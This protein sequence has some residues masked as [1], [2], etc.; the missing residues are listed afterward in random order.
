MEK[1]IVVTAVIPAQNGCNLHC[2]GC[3]ISQRGEAGTNVL[4]SEDY[5]RFTEDTLA[6][7]EVSSFSLQ[8]FEP[9]LPDAWPLAK[10]LLRI[11][12]MATTPDGVGKRVLCVT[13]G[14]YLDRHAE[15][16]VHIT[17]SLSVSVDSHDSAIHDLSRGVVGAWQDTIRGI[18]A[19]RALFGEEVETF[20]EYLGVVSI[21]YPGKVNRLLGMPE[22]LASLGVKRWTVSPLISIAKDGFHGNSQLIR[23]NILELADKAN[24]YGVEV[25]LGDDL[26]Q[27]ESVEDLYKVLSVAAVAGDHV[28]VRLSPDASLSVGKEILGNSADSQKWDRVESP[29][30]FLKRT[31]AKKY[32]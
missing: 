10:E 18:R 29:V 19:V 17:D 20:Q 25:F 14:V 32:S 6:M 9:L 30:Q 4:T 8:G 2:A 5:L 3:I 31:V 21:L 26:R 16:L 1:R 11:A 12:T 27:L 7:P 13:N 23:D 22:L 24:E 28:V 15:E